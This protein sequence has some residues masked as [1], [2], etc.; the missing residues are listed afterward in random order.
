MYKFAALMIQHLIHIATFTTQEGTNRKK[1]QGETLI[2]LLFEKILKTNTTVDVSD[3]YTLIKDIDK[4]TTYRYR[5]WSLKN[6]GLIKHLKR[7]TY[8]LTPKGIVRLNEAKRKITI[9]NNI[10]QDSFK[11]FNKAINA[12]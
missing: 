11:V 4:V 9:T 6:D 2:L 5:I 12:K 1:H 3:I 10:L 8:V 7:S